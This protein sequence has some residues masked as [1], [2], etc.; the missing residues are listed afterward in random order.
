LTL[1][2]KISDVYDAKGSEKMGVW[3]F[4]VTHFHSEKHSFGVKAVTCHAW[5]R[6]RTGLIW[7][8]LK[9]SGNV[10]P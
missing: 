5:N 6:S 8:H 4:T 3:H 2:V 1:K 7:T 10:L 9:E